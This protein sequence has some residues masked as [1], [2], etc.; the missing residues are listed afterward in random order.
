MPHTCT[1][2]NT[3]CNTQTKSNT[4]KTKENTLLNLTLARKFLTKKAIHKDN[5]KM[6]TLTKQDKGQH[7]RHSH[8]GRRC[9]NVK[10][11]TTQRQQTHSRQT[12]ETNT[13]KPSRDLI[14]RP[15]PKTKI[16]IC[17]YKATLKKYS[18]STTQFSLRRPR[19]W[20]WW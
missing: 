19:R 10:H 2:N 6:K 4:Y 11:N 8:V 12:F 17:K 3:S 13:N 5:D 1:L 16:Q 15:R 9:A 20:I 7:T 14:K 18:P